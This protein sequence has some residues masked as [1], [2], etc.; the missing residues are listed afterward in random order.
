MFIE[1][2]PS[3]GEQGQT[4]NQHRYLI[5]EYL[6]ILLLPLNLKSKNLFQDFGEDI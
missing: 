2:L 3:E 1:L 6:Q 5:Y 4:E